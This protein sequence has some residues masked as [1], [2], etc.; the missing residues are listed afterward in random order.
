MKTRTIHL[1]LLVSYSLICATNARGGDSSNKTPPDT[2]ITWYR[3]LDEAVK[4]AT[5][6]NLY[7]LSDFYTDWC[8]WC[9]VQD[10]STFT[11]PR[12]IAFGRRFVFAKINAEID[13]A[14]A[15]RYGVNGY[16]T[17]IVMDKSGH[18]ID[19]LLGYNPP[20]QFVK[21]VED[22]LDGVGTLA[23]LEKSLKE[24]S[25]D[26][27]LL[28]AVG[29]K[30]VGKGE[31]E[32]AR[33]YFTQVL[34]FD[35]K[36][37]S[38]AADNALFDLAILHRKDRSWYKAAETFRKLIKQYPDSE[39]REDAETYIPW[40]LSKAGDTEGALKAYRGFLKDFPSSSQADWVKEQ[41]KTLE[42]PRDSSS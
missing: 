26:T 25:Q 11:D 15:G 14:I 41:I 28:L 17:V 2:A 22:Y 31:F 12:V 23:A 27:K 4:I 6:S 32:K 5:D 36:N 30:Y 10:E 9:K 20:G 37:G 39:L 24:K 21:T 13:T 7:V 18:E 8:K 42:N 33:G 34:N 16:P 19:R 3:S 35:P 1:L 29:E 40:L 38:G